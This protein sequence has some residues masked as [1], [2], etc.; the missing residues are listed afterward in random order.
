M[1]V[2]TVFLVYVLGWF[3]GGLCMDR[4]V[5]RCRMMWRPT[6]PHDVVQFD[7]QESRSPSFH[8]KQFVWEIINDSGKRMLFD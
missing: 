2:R 1:N 3:L 5:F 8:Q 4:M 6:I 7:G